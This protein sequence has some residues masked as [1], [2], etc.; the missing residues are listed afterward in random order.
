MQNIIFKDY[1]YGWVGNIH[2]QVLFQKIDVGSYVMK[3]KFSLYKLTGDIVYPMRP[4]FYSSFKGEK[5]WI[6]N[7]QSTFESYTIQYKDI[8]GKNF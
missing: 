2:D 4:W 8:S 7:I 3:G 5:R 1:N 6:A